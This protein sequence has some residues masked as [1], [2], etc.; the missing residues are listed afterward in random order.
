VRFVAALESIRE[1]DLGGLHLSYSAANHS[2][3]RYVNITALGQ[4]GRLIH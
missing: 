3:L 2:G 4:S 1:L